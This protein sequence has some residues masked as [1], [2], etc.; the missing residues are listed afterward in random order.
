MAFVKAPS[1][2]KLININLIIELPN[3]YPN[4]FSEFCAINGLK[5]PNIT[6]ENCRSLSV[7]LKYRYY[8][9]N[10]DVCDKFVEK[11]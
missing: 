3:E 5:P 11:I 6:T 10:R 4:D 9:W 8:Y 2:Y 7:M 1:D